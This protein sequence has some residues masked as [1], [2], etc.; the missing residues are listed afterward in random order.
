[1][2]GAE[3][4]SGGARVLT[5]EEAEAVLRADPADGELGSFEQ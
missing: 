3:C 4:R 5:M 1:M 2:D